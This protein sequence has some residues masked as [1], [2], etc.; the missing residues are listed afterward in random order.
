MEEDMLQ[1]MTMNEM[2][3]VNG[4]VRTVVK[5]VVKALRD[6][7]VY[8]VVKTVV[9]WVNQ[10]DNRSSIPYQWTNPRSDNYSS[11]HY[12]GGRQTDDQYGRSW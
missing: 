8:D 10:P 1:E 2:Q 6:G 7:V 9:K 3:L 12:R 4:G 11:N 5:I